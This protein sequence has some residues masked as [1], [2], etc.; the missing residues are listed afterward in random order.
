MIPP[1]LKSGDTIAVV[2]T[3][4]W[5]DEAQL[6]SARAVFESWG[7]RTVSAPN[8]S[9]RHFQ[10]AGKD[11]FRR[12]SLQEMLDR[13]DI[14]AVVVARGG[15][16]TVRLVDELDFEGMRKFPKWLVGFSDV[17]VL[18]NA[19]NNVGIATI[20]GPMP[21]TFGDATAEALQ[22]LK[23]CLFGVRDS[24]EFVGN[25]PTFQQQSTTI[26]GGNLS[27][28]ASQL[29]SS[30]QIDTKGKWIFL[31]DVDEM[32]YHIDRMLIALKRAGIFKDCAGILA[33]GFSDMR[34][35]TKAYSFATDN[36]WGQDPLDMLRILAVELNIPL[37][38]GFPAGHQKDNRAFYLGRTC[39][40][41][42]NGGVSTIRYQAE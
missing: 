36:P 24:I 16:G 23:D 28:I 41:A 9:E 7:L 35:N 22:S 11:D 19:L 29:G 21:F 27:V 20:H 34:D 25:A 1:F 4:R 40:I 37:L 17:T 26:V 39:S 18:H 8:L 42:S 30:S 10:L 3:A 5:I 31:E 12:Q 38:T 6:A 13:D 15:Y 14:Q 32:L 33:G 2:A